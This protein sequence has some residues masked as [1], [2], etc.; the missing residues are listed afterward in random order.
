MLQ[1]YRQPPTLVM[2]LKLDLHLISL[3][4]E[5][6]HNRKAAVKDH[7]G[8]LSLRALCKD[9][10]LLPGWLWRHRQGALC[11]RHGPPAVLAVGGHWWYQQRGLPLLQRVPGHQH[12]PGA[13]APA[14]GSCAAG[15]LHVHSRCEA[16][17]Q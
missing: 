12:W 11:A 16:M 13:G 17:G 6:V 15:T 14:L 1:A 3:S 7:S 2:C 5:S 4:N 9:P 8:S 10:H